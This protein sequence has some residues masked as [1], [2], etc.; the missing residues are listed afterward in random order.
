MSDDK[1]IRPFDKVAE[2][3]ACPIEV[4]SSSPVFHCSHGQLEIDV[5]E[6]T[7]RCSQCGAMLDPFD[8]LAKQGQELKF[9]WGRYREVKK[10]IHE[11][12]ESVDRLAREEKRLKASI[13]RNKEKLPVLDVRREP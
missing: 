6:R 3:P 5:Y 11:L 1:V 7:V 8:Y 4:K 12:N 2:I 9:M 10:R 13:R